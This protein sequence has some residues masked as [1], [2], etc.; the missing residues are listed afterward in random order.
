M[1]ADMGLAVHAGHGLTLANVGPVAGIPEIQELNIGHSIVSRALFVG[2]AEA[3]REMRAAM[4]AGRNTG[5]V[6]D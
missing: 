6:N 4:D 2:M 3:V 1:A 5:R